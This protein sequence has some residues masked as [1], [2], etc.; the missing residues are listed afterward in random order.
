[1]PNELLSRLKGV[2]S[3]WALI[4]VFMLGLALVLMPAKKGESTPENSGFD[5]ASYVNELENELCS[6]ISHISGAGKAQVMVTIENSPEQYYQRNTKTRRTDADA[7]SSGESEETVV[8]EDGEP[9]LVKEIL[10]EVR[11]VAVVCGGAANSQVAQKIINLV[12]CALNLPTNR[13]YVT[14]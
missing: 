3:L 11:G 1:M 7:S 6:I 8:F 5:T 10:P 14:Y 12:S 2:K 13:I 9:I 4:A